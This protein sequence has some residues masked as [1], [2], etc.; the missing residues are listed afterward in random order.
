MEI[1]IAEEYKGIILS[2]TEKIIN[3]GYDIGKSY[4]FLILGELVYAVLLRQSIFVNISQDHEY[5]GRIIE[6]YEDREI[7]NDFFNQ[8]FSELHIWDSK[9]CGISEKSRISYKVIGYIYKSYGYDMLYDR[10]QDTII[11]MI[12]NNYNISASDYQ[13]MVNRYLGKISIIV[14][15]EDSFSEIDNVYSAETNFRGSHI[16]CVGSTK[17][18]AVDKVY[19]TIAL[20]YLSVSKIQQCVD[21]TIYKS[22]LKRYLVNDKNISTN[23]SINELSQ[24]F[25]IPESLIAFCMMPANACTDSYWH[26]QGLLFPTYL[27]PSVCDEKNFKLSLARMGNHIIRL[28][29]FEYKLSMGNINLIDLTQFDITA[30]GVISYVKMKYLDKCLS[31]KHFCDVILSQIGDAIEYKQ[32]NFLHSFISCFFFSNFAPEKLFFS[33]FSDKLNANLSNKTKFHINYEIETS[34]FLGL[35]KCHTIIKNYNE[36]NGCFGT[37]FLICSK[38]EKQRHSFF[39]CKSLDASASKKNLWRIAYHEI[40]EETKKAFSNPSAEINEQIFPFIVRNLCNVRHCILKY[41]LQEYGLF[42]AKNIDIIGFE[43]FAKIWANIKSCLDENTLVKLKDK[44]ISL[45]ENA[46]VYIN[47][48]IHLYSEII[49]HIADSSPLTKQ[50]INIYSKEFAD[51]YSRIVN[52]SICM[53]KQIVSQDPGFIGFIHNPPFEV[54][55]IALDSDLKLFDKIESPSKKIIMYYQARLDEIKHLSADNLGQLSCDFDD[56]CKLFIFDSHK[57]FSNQ[58]KEMLSQIKVTQATIACGYFFKSGLNLINDILENYLE[59]QIPLTFII[60]SLQNYTET[61]DC[62]H[63]TGIDKATVHK[64]NEYLSYPTVKLYTCT[65]RFYHGKLYFFQ[66]IDKSLIC[67]GSSNVSRAAF[68]SN[69]ELNIAMIVQSGSDFNQKI[70]AW[71]KQLIFYSKQINTLDESRFGDNEMN[72]ES[73][74]VIKSVPLSIIRKKIDELTDS[75]LKYRHSLWQS[76]EPD[77]CY[78]E[79]GIASLPY[80]VAYVYRRYNLL[81]LESFN[82]GNSYFCIKYEKELETVFSNISTLSKTEIFNYSNMTKRGYH[83]TNRFTLESNIRAYFQNE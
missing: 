22:N 31:T 49:H 40:I 2:T 19:R 46:L 42:C 15:L 29:T 81:V 63:I 41:Y 53:Q 69:Y 83:T 32:N 47:D 13:K 71:I 73:G 28:L 25:G 39:Y 68:V 70:S 59:H 20:R 23:S 75:E 30:P 3:D 54:A 82:P 64:L 1:T 35:L 48:N 27:H 14:K 55:K 7:L 21:I 79:L 50:G 45:N 37:E 36:S 58:L 44:I 56:N 10:F 62:E 57:P 16:H 8:Y 6:N 18:S 72:L 66:G 76:Y 38:F 9:F 67:L 80:Y 5:A 34:S 4:E 61:N 17:K 26:S 78:E 65:D 74:I 77:D 52:P 43:N 51:L 24:K 33:I 60:G 11:R 12:D